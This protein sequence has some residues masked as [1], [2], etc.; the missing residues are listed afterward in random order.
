MG[1]YGK[2]WECGK[3]GKFG[4]EHRNTHSSHAAHA[5]H[6]PRTSHTPA[7]LPLSRQRGIRSD[8]VE[9]AR[10]NEHDEEFPGVPRLTGAWI[11]AAIGIVGSFVALC[12][13]TYQLAVQ[14]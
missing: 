9:P 12:W 14:R 13:I 2:C 1:E 3:Y 6:T 5:P 8:P 10:V 7:P 11:A 4:P